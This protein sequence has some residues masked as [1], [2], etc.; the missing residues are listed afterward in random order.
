MATDS[1][2][3][4]WEIPWTEAP[5]V[6]GVTK[7]SDTVQ[8]LNTTNISNFLKNPQLLN[9]KSKVQKGEGT[10]FRKVKEPSS[11]RQMVDDGATM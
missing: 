10:F 5:A 1:R 4:A 7:E 6:H 8:G 3:L 11:D 9:D 2:I